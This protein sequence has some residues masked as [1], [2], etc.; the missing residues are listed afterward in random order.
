[1][2]SRSTFKKLQKE[3]SRREKQREKLERKRQ[4][5]LEKN[6]AVPPSHD[7]SDS[8]SSDPGSSPVEQGS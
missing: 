7:L 8:V 3:R 6:S 1:M 4:R 5:K 2:S